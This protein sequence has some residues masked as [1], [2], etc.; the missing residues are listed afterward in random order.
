MLAAMRRLLTACLLA[1]ATF[2]LSAQSVPAPANLLDS[3]H[4]L[5]GTWSAQTTAPDGS[6]AAAVSGTYTFRTDL[7]GH[8]IE[9]TSSEDSCKA[10]SSF[11]CN[12]HDRLTIFAD[13]N[14]LTSVHRAALFA[15]YLDNEGHVIYYAVSTPDPHTAIFNSQAAPSAPKFRLIYHLEGDGPKAVMS[16]KFQMATPGSDDFHSYLEWSGTKQ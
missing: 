7:G 11:D 6:A 2:G 16:G 8:A 9:R 3:L 4:F 14:G 1:A 5:L 12:H 15:F 10:P 13:P